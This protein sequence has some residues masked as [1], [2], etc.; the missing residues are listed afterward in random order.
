MKTKFY[1]LL[2]MIGTALSLSSC[3]NDDPWDDFS[4]VKPVIELPYSSHS[5]SITSKNGQNV[6]FELMVNYTIADWRNQNDEIVVGLGID[7]S[8]IGKNLLLPASAY[9]LPETMTIVEQ[10]QLTTTNLTVNVTGLAAGKYILPIVIK[11]VP[12]GYTM[13]GN[14]NYVLFT[15]NVQ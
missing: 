5:R 3:L 1:Y 6:T 4:T 8:L 15:V 10:T 11:S 13:S 12:A 14:F 2:I 7:E 9:S